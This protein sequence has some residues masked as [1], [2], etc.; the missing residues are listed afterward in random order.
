[1][2]ESTLN[3]SLKRVDSKSRLQLVLLKSESIK[4]NS[5][6]KKRLSEFYSSNVNLFAWFSHS[7]ESNV[8]D[9]SE[10]NA[11]CNQLHTAGFGLTST[12]SRT[13]FHI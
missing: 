5:V 13:S 7:S 2:W 10:Q 6:R 9:S 4:V 3:D 12:S 8:W 11:H 1:M